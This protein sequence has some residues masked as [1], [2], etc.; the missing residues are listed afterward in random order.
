MAVGS[1]R[2][3][4]PLVLTIAGIGAATGCAI[5][6]QHAERAGEASYL[7]A[8]MRERQE[9][10]RRI[11]PYTSLA[12][13]LP[14]TAFKAP[15]SPQQSYSETLVR[16]RIVDVEPGV[17][18]T[19]SDADDPSGSLADFDAPTVAWRT[20]HLKLH[21][22]SVIV[23]E[24]VDSSLQVGY[25]VDPND[26]FKQLRRDFLALPD[27]ILPLDRS[28]VYAY[29]PN[30]WGVAGNGA[31]LATVQNGN[32]SLPFL[33][34]DEESQ[35]LVGVKSLAELEKAAKAPARTLPAVSH[36][37]GLAPATS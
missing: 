22:D 5:P 14:N 15:G 25:S 10:A 36:G 23:G 11:V 31:L 28:P 32:L 13:V 8:V 21:V 2:N 34:S 19:I 30:V 17:G 6:Q 33:S 35:M 12:E 18:F 1:S 27:V 4:L 26:D 16:G 29:Q 37:E 9:A 7:V 3:Y 24:P 20:I